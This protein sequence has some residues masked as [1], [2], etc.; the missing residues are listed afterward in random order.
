MTPLY[1]KDGTLFSHDYIRV[2]NG[3]RGKYVE[4]S[5]EMLA[6]DLVSKF[7]QPLPEELSDEKFWYYWCNPKGRKE[8]VYW[9]VKSMNTD[10][11]TDGLMYAVY[12]R[13]LYYI[14][15]SALMPFEEKI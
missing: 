10:K 15:P 11:S 9:Q 7:N 13:N 3:G 8:K 6:V 1:F 2:E 4:L 5:K 14:S 12:H